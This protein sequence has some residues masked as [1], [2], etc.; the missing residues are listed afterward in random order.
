MMKRHIEAAL[1]ACGRDRVLHRDGLGDA[2]IAIRY[3]MPNL[4][5]SPDGTERFLVRKATT[6]DEAGKQAAVAF[7]THLRTRAKEAIE[8]A[9]R[10]EQALSRGEENKA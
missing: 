9:E 7:A 8:W 1:W 2:E 4:A 3:D 6:F 10:I 5:V